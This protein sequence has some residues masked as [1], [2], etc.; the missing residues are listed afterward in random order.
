[1]ACTCIPSI[2]LFYLLPKIT[3]P[4]IPTSP[5][6][7]PP[8]KTSV[9][10]KEVFLLVVKTKP[11]RYI[12]AG[13][14]HVG[15]S[16]I[17]ILIFDSNGFSIADFT[18]FVVKPVLGVNGTGYIVGCFFIAGGVGSYVI[19]KLCGNKFIGRKKM[20][21]F[22]AICE[23]ASYIYMYFYKIDPN[24]ITKFDKIFAY[25]YPCFFNFINVYWN[26]QMPSFLQM[27]YSDNE[28]KQAIA[29]I[30]IFY[31]INYRF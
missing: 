28:F 15:I 23:I 31:Y 21:I 12:I 5:N 30:V 16:Y 11:V 13:C 1:M 22:T 8:K 20:A 2:L 6:S 25:A 26:S 7:L 4:E 19:G 14:F 17:Y 29:R 27:F 3:F 9:S 24:N 10:I 18:K